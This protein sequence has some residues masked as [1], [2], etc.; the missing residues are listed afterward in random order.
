MASSD[1]VR[2]YLAYWF[3]LGKKVFLQGG[4][5][6]VLP[7]PVI[8]GDRYSDSFEACWQQIQSPDAGDC[9][10]EGTE[11]TI[12]E[13]L[14]DGWEV[15]DCAR[16]TMPVPIRSIGLNVLECPCVDLP[17]WP[18]TELPQPRSPVSSTAR[19]EAIREQ[20]NPSTLN[21]KA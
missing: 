20:L 1:Q 13:L 4:H 6:A 7:R 11:Q 15:T 12:A 18:N 5:K 10:L 16:C 8:A 3:Q 19:L 14:S 21:P 9:Y 2:K 17:T